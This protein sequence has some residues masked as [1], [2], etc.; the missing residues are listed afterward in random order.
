ML[1][2]FAETKPDPFVTS[3]GIFFRS[4]SSTMM[5]VIAKRLRFAQAAGTP[6]VIP[7]FY[8]IDND[9]IDDEIMTL[10]HDRPPHAKASILGHQ[11]VKSCIDN[12]MQRSVA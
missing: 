9:G 11:H 4:E 7:A 6:Q 12:V 2:F 1:G 8:D 5:R 3:G 10:A